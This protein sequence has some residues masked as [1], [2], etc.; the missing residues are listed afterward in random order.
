M[1][2][3]TRRDAADGA[4]QEVGQPSQLHV[5][6][7]NMSKL[8]LA[9]AITLPLGVVTK[10]LV[11]RVL[12]DEQAGILYFAE[13][14]PMVVLSLIPMG[15]PVYLKKF[16]PPKPDHAREI[17][18]TVMSFGAFVAAL[19]ILGLIVYLPLAGYDALTV[20]VT[21]IMVCSQAGVVFASSFLQ[22]FFLET[23]LVTLSSVLSVA[24]KLM[25]VL[26]VLLCL[27]LKP[28]IE[29]V[30]SA[31]LAAQLLFI[32]VAMGQARSL[33]W[34]RGGIDFALLKRMLVVGRPFMFGGVLATMSQSIDSYCLS[35][36]ASFQELGYYSAMQ[37]LLS[38]LLLLSPVVAQAF[39]P[40]LSR[41]F[42]QDGDEFT[43][44]A[45]SVI[46]VL[47]IVA[48][49]MGLGLIVFSSEIVD[50]LYGRDFGP[51]RYSLVVAGPILMFAYLS[52]YVGMIATIA[53][54]GKFFTLILG[55]GALINLSANWL[56]I[57]LGASWLGAGGAAAGSAL[58][59]LLATSSDTI[60][61]V[62][63]SSA[64]IL[65][66][67]SLSAILVSL[68]L[69]GI[70]AFSQSSWSQLALGLRI[71]G[72]VVMVPLL[73][74]LTRIVTPGDIAMLRALARRK[75]TGA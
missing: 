51:A 30:A 7:A 20:R 48:F 4:R 74:L 55:I 43:K 5:T 22:R 41:L 2:E 33:G 61:L 24:G 12:G 56:L 3:P 18:V 66:K 42:A 53:T 28:E 34:L 58:A 9:L 50:L 73:M 47:A 23:G 52:T 1:T 39:G 64:R 45:S 16:L 27:W 60:L 38:I 26:L 54:S 10:V 35:H 40:A 37:R 69:M 13:V 14:F 36:L 57:P 65:D 49:P 6:L 46:R 15:I 59:T 44:M 72:F 71:G 32:L 17:F 62:I 75:A 70:F 21:A 63:A 8:T 67:R 68:G 29:W 31:F 25:T 11:P 19:A